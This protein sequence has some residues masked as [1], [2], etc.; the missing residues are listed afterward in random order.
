MQ[1]LEC[2]S[3]FECLMEMVDAYTITRLDEEIPQIFA[4]NQRAE[5][6]KA[7]AYGERTKRKK[8]Y[9]PDTMP[10]LNFDEGK[11]GGDGT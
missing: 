1:D 9:S 5:N 11:E 2:S 3:V 6:G 8:S 4:D 7:L 10:T